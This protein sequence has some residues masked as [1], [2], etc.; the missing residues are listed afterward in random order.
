MKIHKEEKISL[1]LTD[2][3]SLHKYYMYLIS[4]E[5]KGYVYVSEVLETNGD[6]ITFRLSVEQYIYDKYPHVITW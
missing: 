4:L 1:N 5:K 6:W 2:T 3:S